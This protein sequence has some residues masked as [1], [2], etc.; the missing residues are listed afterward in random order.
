MGIA[1]QKAQRAKRDADVPIRLRE[2]A[3]IKIQNIPRNPGD[4]LGCLQWT[5][6][7]SGQV[8]RW[9]VLI[10][11]RRDQVILRSPD[12]RATLSHGWTW[13]LTHLRKK[14]AHA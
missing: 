9:T 3:E 8:R 7:R 11:A 2:L 5:D 1:S 12:G 4:A 6:F 14:L 10:G 13:V